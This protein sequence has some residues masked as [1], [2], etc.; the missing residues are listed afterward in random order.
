MRWEVACAFA[1]IQKDRCLGFGGRRR[2]LGLVLDVRWEWVYVFAGISK[3]LTCAGSN[4][5]CAA[6]GCGLL[7]GMRWSV[8]MEHANN[9]IVKKRAASL[10]ALRLFPF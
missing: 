2:A 9:F 1:G 3:E 4:R 5:T 10:T 8:D 6:I 7:T